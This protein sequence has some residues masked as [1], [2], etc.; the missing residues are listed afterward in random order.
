MTWARYVFLT[1]DLVRQGHVTVQVIYLISGL[2]H[3]R[4]INFF[5]SMVCW[6]KKVNAM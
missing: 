2:V 1:R 4:D 5:V 6:I 3:A